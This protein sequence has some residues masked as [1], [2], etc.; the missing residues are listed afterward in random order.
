MASMP[1]PPSCCQPNVSPHIDVTVSLLWLPTT[2]RQMSKLSA[3][4]RGL[5]WSGFMSPLPPG[6]ILVHLPT[7]IPTTPLTSMP[8]APPPN[9]ACPLMPPSLLPA[10]ESCL[11]LPTAIH[12]CVNETPHSNKHYGALTGHWALAGIHG[13]IIVFM[14]HHDVR[15]TA[16][17]REA[18]LSF[19]L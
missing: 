2:L 19:L 10:L 17:Q 6:S 18:R 15:P 5:L 9:P 13:N 12:T 3:W 11:P 16:E 8:S 4:L 1:L 14:T 7:L